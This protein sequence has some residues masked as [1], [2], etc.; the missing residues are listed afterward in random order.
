MEVRS[1]SFIRNLAV[2]LV[3][4]LFSVDS[5]TQS[6]KNFIVSRISVEKENQENN[7]ASTLGTNGY[8]DA[9]YKLY[10]TALRAALHNLIK[11]HTV[12]SYDGLYT[13]FVSTDSKPNGKIWD[14]YSDVPNGTPAYEYSH[15]SKKCGSYTQEGD[16][17]NREHSWPDS[18]LGAT[19]PARSDLFHMYP[20]D[21]YVNNRRS[22]YPF[23]KVGSATWTSTNGS[24]V[25]TCVYP[26]YSGIVFEPINEFKGDL[27]RSSMYMS[28]RYYTEDGAW[29]TTPATNKSDILPWYANIL[30]DWS[31]IDTVSLKE[32]NRNNAIFS[33][34]KNRN[35]FIDHP[36]YAAEIWKTTMAPA[37]VSV[38][39]M[40]SS[41]IL[42]DFSRYLDSTVAVTP[43]NF[44]ID[45]S[46]GNPSSIGWGVNSDIS[47]ILIKVPALATGTTYSIELKNLKSINNIPMKD[48]VITFKTAGVSGLDD[49]LEMPQGFVLHQ[50]YPNPFNPS[51][52]ISWRLAVSSFTTLKVYD[53]LGNEVAELV[54]NFLE[55]GNYNVEFNAS[56]LSSG[57]YF[58]SLNA[59]SHHELRKMV[60]IK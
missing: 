19:N 16:C 59:G 30:Y 36:E 1:G 53:V 33:I 57:I 21:G 3:V 32:I 54:N 41:S 11:G 7:P 42:I 38:K 46:I 5:Y 26:G 35:P 60:M 34:Q 15:G 10:G 49:K 51:T 58:Y 45:H 9:T 40:N 29:I 37:V 24:K 39:E 20:T 18:W 25:G 43:Q 23:G 8:Y 6:D 47:K 27:A 48:T 44:I 55:A 17:Y 2:G 28:V 52:M 31:V 4:I 13:A 22:N 56:S 14:I 50:N 12:T